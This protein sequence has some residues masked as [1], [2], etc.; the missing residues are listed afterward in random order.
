MKP[1]VVVEWTKNV[2]NRKLCYMRSHSF[3]TLNEIAGSV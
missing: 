3:T 1:Y 2:G